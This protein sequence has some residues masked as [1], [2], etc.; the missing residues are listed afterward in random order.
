MSLK[1]ILDSYLDPVLD[2]DPYTF[3]E[4]KEDY[5]NKEIGKDWYDEEVE[6][7]KAIWNAIPEKRQE[8]LQSGG[9]TTL[10]IAGETWSKARE[11]KPWYQPGENLGALGIR[12]I[13]GLGWLSN[14]LI[15]QPVSHAAHNW[16]GIHKPVAGGIGLGTE[17]VLDPLA[18]GKLSKISNSRKAQKF[19]HRLGQE[20]RYHVDSAAF[21]VNKN[22]NR[23]KTDVGW[24]KDQIQYATGNKL[25]P[26]TKKPSVYTDVEEIFEGSHSYLRK[27]NKIY[28]NHE[29]GISWKKAME[30]AKKNDLQM[31]IGYGNEIMN[32]GDNFNYLP[33]LGEDDL[34][35]IKKSLPNKTDQL[36]L[37]DIEE[38]VGPLDPKSRQA[39]IKF[40]KLTAEK[41]GYE[42]MA[43][44]KREVLN[45]WP[46]KDQ[47]QIFRELWSNRRY[48]GYVEHL[49]SKASSMDWYWE[50]K[51]LDRN[52][53][54]NV[55]ILYNDNLKNLKDTVEKIVHGIKL[56]NG[57]FRPG[58]GWQSPNLKDRLIVTFEDPMKKTKKL[59]SRQNPGDIVIKRAGNDKIIGNLGQYLDVLY[60]QDPVSKRL[61][62]QGLQELGI[63]PADFRR[64]ILTKRIETIIENSNTLPSNT[65]ARKR[66]IKKNI[67]EDMAQLIEQYPFLQRPKAISK[68]ID[69]PGSGM[70]P[71]DLDKRSTSRKGPFPSKTEQLNIEK[72]KRKGYI[73]GNLEEFLN[74]IFPDD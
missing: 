7:L 2:R 67:D 72:A 17:I 48:Q 35:D 43:E 40:N 46:K 64:Q 4:L 9:K 58:M 36:D 24:A 51:G 3:N 21:N 53:V 38:F 31:N 28:Q 20:T 14:K 39:A 68:Q 34:I 27:A 62:N 44:F 26:L 10:N 11:F 73:Q 74:N 42:S 61:F 65:T 49:T 33:N 23:I 55:R 8:Q 5:K 69:T 18:I 22:V 56:P 70:S 50:M 54:E 71:T 13:E 59:F 37:F 45:R 57:T 41:S 1:R 25:R 32:T 47:D 12:G 6:K 29:G 66:Y 16:L 30:I 19:V 63:K 15:G 60:P 52:A